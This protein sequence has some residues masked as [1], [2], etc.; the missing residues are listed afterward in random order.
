M[1]VRGRIT[2]RVTSD[3]ARPRCAFPG[4]D[5]SG[6]EPCAGERLRGRVVDVGDRV[7]GGVDGVHPRF[8][9]GR[10]E[11]V[12]VDPRV[13]VD[14]FGHV[15]VQFGREARRV[16]GLVEQQVLI[17]RRIGGLVARSALGLLVGAVVVRGVEALIERLVVDAVVERERLEAVLVGNLTGVELVELGGLLAVVVET[18]EVVAAPF[19]VELAELIHRIPHLLVRGCGPWRAPRRAA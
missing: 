12:E 4:T 9:L 15:Q 11:G 6:P 2:W 7:L 13:A 3:S 10:A 5:A 8:G 18:G 14:R 1:R 16:V 19:R 17:G